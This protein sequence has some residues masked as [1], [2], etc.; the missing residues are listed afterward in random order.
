MDG[1]AD[2]VVAFPIQDGLYYGLHGLPGGKVLYLSHPL[3]GSLKRMWFPSA[4]AAKASLL[5]YDIH[6]AKRE[7]LVSGVSSYAVSADHKALV[8]RSA[9]RLR[10]MK[11]GEK[12]DDS[13]AREKPGRR[14]G[15]IDLSRI[16]LSVCP[17]AEWRQMFDEAWR[18][19]LENFW[20][21]D[22]SGV[23][24]KAVRT[25]YL[26]LLDRVGSRGEFSDLM[27]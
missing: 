11:A 26:P 21:P 8:Y 20:A 10:V 23:D 15:W 12:S 9:N 4:P 25:Q 18:L 2:R 7:T 19:Q 3:E 24:W 5:M 22:M 17:S 6:E 27:W 1:I 16:K 14:S 13:A